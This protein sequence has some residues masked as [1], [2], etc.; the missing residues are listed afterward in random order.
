MTNREWLNSLS[1]EELVNWIYMDRTKVFDMKENKIVI[2]APNCSPCLTEVVIGWT[3]Y[4]ERL[5][6]WLKEERK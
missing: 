5:K 1:N 4:Q 2:F 3:S 6:Q